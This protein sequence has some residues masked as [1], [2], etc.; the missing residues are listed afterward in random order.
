MTAYADTFATAGIADV[1]VVSFWIVAA[2]AIVGA[3]TRTAKRVPRSLWLVPLI[4]WASVAPITT[5]TPRFR[6]AI[7]PF[8]ILLAAFAIHAIAGRSRALRGPR[9]VP[10]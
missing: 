2:L 7:D 1:G 3:F 8:V 6:S 5:G 4:L 10:S 9:A